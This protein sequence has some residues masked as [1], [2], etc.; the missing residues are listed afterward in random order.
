MSR[1]QL[2]IMRPNEPV[3]FA[4]VQL[5]RLKDSAISEPLANPARFSKWV[6][7]QGPYRLSI[8]RET[9]ELPP[10]REVLRAASP[11]KKVTECSQRLKTV[12]DDLSNR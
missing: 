6:F 4:L 12:A 1:S 10:L 11:F 2:R 9:K 8:A 7:E 3:R 5:L